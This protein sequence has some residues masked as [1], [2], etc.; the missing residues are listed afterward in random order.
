M[1]ASRAAL[2]LCCLLAALACGQNDS[3]NDSSKAK[4]RPPASQ[5][6]APPDLVACIAEVVTTSPMVAMG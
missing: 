1:N 6:V 3:G 2:I 4:S 5:P